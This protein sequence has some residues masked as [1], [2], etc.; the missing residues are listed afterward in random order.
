MIPALGCGSQTDKLV[1]VGLWNRCQDD[2]FFLMVWLPTGNHALLRLGK[3]A[4]KFERIRWELIRISAN[5]CPWATL[6][7]LL[8]GS[9][10]GQKDWDADK[11]TQWLPTGNLV[12]TFVYK[13]DMSHTEKDEMLG[14]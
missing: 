12:L 11:A 3:C 10:T 14:R 13:K 2:L 9:E 6:L 5:G 7:Y 8:A 1:L 4:K